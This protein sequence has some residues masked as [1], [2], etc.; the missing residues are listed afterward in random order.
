MKR[1]A[2]A[3]RAPALPELTER[4]RRRLRKVTGARQAIL[5]ILR[6]NQRPLTIKQIHE[7]LPDKDCDLATV[8]RSMHLLEDMG[9]VKRF[10][11]GDGGARF[12][13][14]GEGDDGHHHHLVCTRC[15]DVVELDECF[16]HELEKEIAHRNGFKHVSHKLEFFGIC[17]RCQ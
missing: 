4:L 5:E 17:P 2:H 13:L 16:P 1:P 15:S 9:I 6:N 11:L 8:Y 14:L 10:D 3:H 7:G 12:E